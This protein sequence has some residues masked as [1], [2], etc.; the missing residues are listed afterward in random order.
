MDNPELTKVH[1]AVQCVKLLF[2]EYEEGDEIEARLGRIADGV[3]L[4]GINTETSSRIVETLNR[5]PDW[6]CQ[7]EWTETTDYYLEDTRLT[8]HYDDATYQVGRTASRKERGDYINMTTGGAQ[9]LRISKRKEVPVHID[10][11]MPTVFSPTHVR[12]KQ[13]RS[14]T[15]RPRNGEWQGDVWRYDISIIW[16]GRTKTEAERWQ[17]SDRPPIYEVEIEYIG[18]AAYLHHAG[19]DNVSRSMCLKCADLIDDLEAMCP[20]EPAETAR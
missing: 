20:V 10:S 19:T 14:Y 1:A 5:Y 12:I 11:E 3:F 7:T 13:R 16:S 17:R 4:A 18:G 9:D 2:D 6:T 15:Y 8:I